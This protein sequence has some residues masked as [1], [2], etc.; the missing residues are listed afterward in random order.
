MIAVNSQLVPCEKSR[1]SNFNEGRPARCAEQQARSTVLPTSGPCLPHGGIT[2][3]EGGAR[4]IVRAGAGESFYG[5][6][7][8]V[9]SQA[10]FKAATEE[11]RD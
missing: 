8:Q 11:T 4:M 10:T 7:V 2:V 6:A 3:W 5:R 1:G 9:S